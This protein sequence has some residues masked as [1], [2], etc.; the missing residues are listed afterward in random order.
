[1][2]GISFTPRFSEALDA[3]FVSEKYSKI[4]SQG[5][6][7]RGGFSRLEIEKQFIHLKGAANAKGR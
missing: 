3:S 6:S 2:E 7:L 5:D 4:F 1:M